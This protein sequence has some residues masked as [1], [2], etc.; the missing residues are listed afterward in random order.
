MISACNLDA[1][2]CLQ[3]A[4]DIFDQYD[5]SVDNFDVDFYALF[6]LYIA[7]NVF[8]FLILWLRVRK[9]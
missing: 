1:P 2:I 5:F 3:T 8:A 7:F 4:E 9:N 6:I